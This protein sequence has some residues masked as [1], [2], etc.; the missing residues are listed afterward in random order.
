MEIQLQLSV[1]VMLSLEHKHE[2]CMRQCPIGGLKQRRV[3]LKDV[4]HMVSIFLRLVTELLIMHCKRPRWDVPPDEP[5]ASSSSA[6]WDAALAQNAVP[7]HVSQAW[8][9]RCSYK[10]RAVRFATMLSDLALYV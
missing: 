10:C 8:D 1:P 4:V 3:K 5:S 9:V 6:A 7:Q 2:R